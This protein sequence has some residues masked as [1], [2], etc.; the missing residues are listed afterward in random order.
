MITEVRGG[1]VPIAGISISNPNP[2]A[3]RRVENTLVDGGVP[4]RRLL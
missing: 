2:D 3:Y 1:G 4:E